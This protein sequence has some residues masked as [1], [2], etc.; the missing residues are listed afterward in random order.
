MQIPVA[1]YHL[2]FSPVAY[3]ASSKRGGSAD[4]Q[5][6]LFF[7]VFLK[8]SQQICAERGGRLRGKRVR[9]P[10]IFIYLFDHIYKLK[11]TIYKTY[12]CIYL[13]A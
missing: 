12:I 1:F 13:P 6:I 7:A 9:P 8:N 2:V 11:S 10:C 5:N 4:A 3:I